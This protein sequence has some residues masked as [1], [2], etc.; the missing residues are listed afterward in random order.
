MCRERVGNVIAI[1]DISPNDS[2]ART[3]DAFDTSDDLNVAI[4]KIVKNDDLVAGADQFDT[5]MGPDVAG[6]ARDHDLHLQHRFREEPWIER[7]LRGHRPAVSA[8]R[9]RW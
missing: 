5:C 6:S 3:R 1:P 2:R 7:F 8:G 9:C 4:A